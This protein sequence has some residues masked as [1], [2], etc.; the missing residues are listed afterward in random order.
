METI[1]FS[2]SDAALEGFQVLGRH[3]RVV[4]GWALFNLVAL[5]ALVVVVVIVGVGIGL[6]AGQD[7]ASRVIVVIGAV[8]GG[9]ATALIE[10]ALI[11]AVYRLM[12]RPSDEGFLH[13]RLGRDEGRLFVVGLLLMGAVMAF[14]ALA[15]LLIGLLGPLGWIGRALGVVLALVAGGFL[16]LRLGLA[17]PIS[18]AEQK[19]DFVRSWRMTRG[20]VWPLFGMWILN[21]CLVMLVWLVIC[22]LTFVMSGLLTGFHGFAGAEGSEA[23]KSHPG[24]YLF[25]AVAP[26]LSMPVLLVLSQAPWLAA[27]QAFIRT[28]GPWDLARRP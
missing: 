25:E 18:F 26:I 21:F 12:L 28:P 23:L 19:I 7:E 9:L 14:T 17:G 20:Q 3:W 16:V 15:Y 24:R 27:Y 2:P 10:T 6:A 22:L 1:R 5:V 8:F 4:A 13:L 11:V